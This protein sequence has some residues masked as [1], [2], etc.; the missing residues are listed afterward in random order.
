MTAAVPI[1]IEMLLCLVFGAVARERARAFGVA[2][3]PTLRT[4]IPAAAAFVPCLLAAHDASRAIS[5]A[6]LTACAAISAVTD[7]ES[8]LI[9]DRVLTV[10]TLLMLPAAAFAGNVAT[11]LA[12]AAAAGALLWLPHGVSRGRA[13]G[14]GDV[15][16]AAVAGFALGPVGGLFALWAAAIGGGLIAAVLLGCRRARRGDALRFGPFLAAGVAFTIAG[17]R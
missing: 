4:G 9:F 3:T 1:A 17:G 10:A 5:I 14:L 11:G 7:L 6:I 12:G 8:G 2:A 16:L 15:K 13:I